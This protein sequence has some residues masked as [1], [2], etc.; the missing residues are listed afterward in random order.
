MGGVPGGVA[1]CGAA[2]LIDPLLAG[3]TAAATAKSGYFF[4]F[5]GATAAPAVAPVVI[6]TILMTK[7]ESNLPLSHFR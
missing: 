2:L 7:G 4:T 5:V 6:G 3:A 1:V